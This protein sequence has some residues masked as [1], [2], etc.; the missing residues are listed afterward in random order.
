MKRI[1]AVLVQKSQL[2]NYLLAGQQSTAVRNYCLTQ[3]GN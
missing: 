2:E 1:P 3:D